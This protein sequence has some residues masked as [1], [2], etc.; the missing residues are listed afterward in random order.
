[1][2]SYFCAFSSLFSSL[3]FIEANVFS[4]SC[5]LFVF[6]VSI[7]TV[8]VSSFS[9]NETVHGVSVME[10]A[11]T[12]RRKLLEI[13]VFISMV[14]TFAPVRISLIALKAD[15]YTSPIR[16]NGNKASLKRLMFVILGKGRNR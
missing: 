3:F 7:K 6:P 4:V 15:E 11:S 14:P 13:C 5:R 9:S 2:F 10:L 16:K 12:V 1:M 8:I